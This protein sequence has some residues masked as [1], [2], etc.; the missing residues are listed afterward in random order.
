MSQTRQFRNLLS[1]LRPLL[2]DYLAGH[3]VQIDGAGNFRCPNPEHEDK[4]PSCG[5]VSNDRLRFHCFACGAGGDIFQAAHFLEGKPLTG[6]QFLLETVFSLAQQ[7]SITYEDFEVSDHQL[8]QGEIFRAYELAGQ[9]LNHS[10]LDTPLQ[11]TTGWSLEEVRSVDP[12]IGSVAWDDFVKG[13][14]ERGDYTV[15]YLESIGLTNRLFDDYRLTFAIKTPT[16]HICGFAARDTRPRTGKNQKKWTNTPGNVPIFE[17]GSLFYGLHSAKGERGPIYLVE[18]Y[19]DAIALRL[20]GLKKVVAYMGS[21]IAPNQVRTLLQKR[22]TDIVL[23]PDR[24]ENLAG[25]QAS[26]NAIEKVFAGQ[27][28]LTVRVKELPPKEWTDD[29]HSYDPFDYIKDHSLEDFLRL[30]EQPAFNWML[31]RLQDELSPEEKCSKMFKLVLAEPSAIR[32]EQMLTEL[33][34]KTGVRLVALRR[35][36]DRLLEE[37]RQEVQRKLQRKVDHLRSSLEQEDPKTLPE[38]LRRTALEM[39]E[40]QGIK[41]S[42]D[43]HGPDET[44]SFAKQ[45]QKE[46]WNQGKE[47]KGWATGLRTFDDTLH[48]I[49]RKEAFIGVGADGNVGKS[50][51][52]QNLALRVATNNEGVCVLIFTID[53][54]RSQTIPRL[55]AQLSSIKIG[56]IEQPQ[57]YTFSPEQNEAMQQAWR[58]LE[59]LIQ[60]GKLDIKDASQGNSLSFAESWIDAVRDA[61]PGRSI[62]FVL[63][64]FHILSGPPEERARVEENSRQISLMCKQKG[65]TVLSTMELRKR[66]QPHKRPRPSDLKGSKKLEYDTNV[67]ILIHSELHAKPDD[68]TA[69]GWI[70]ESDPD[71]AIKK[72]TLQLWF[73]KNKVTSYKGLKEMRFKPDTCQLFE[74]DQTG[75]SPLDDD[76]GFLDA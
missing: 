70:D 31:T 20:R 46:F 53:D 10:S 22:C 51:L 58:T 66:E 49:P 39:E 40:I 1:Q 73:D 61:H 32:Q 71:G 41:F 57:R 5:F 17:K 45:L 28:D 15:T 18:G 59:Q 21:S 16:G 69:Y 11:Q 43:I 12:H 34:A 76:D 44:E 50:A 33:A 14:R 48:G 64:N 67:L 29:C 13:M 52:V 65:V 25:F 27:E 62:L 7:F 63:D 47:L 26:E 35:D 60:D 3:G 75:E 19:T 68:P 8:R 4:N 55:V 37:K 9:I 38:R 36:L 74:D 2:P 24:D 56:W 6:R 23:V 54:T 42:S 30:P 72:P